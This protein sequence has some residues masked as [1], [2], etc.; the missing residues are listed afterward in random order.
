MC[1]SWD[2]KGGKKKNKKKTYDFS[3]SL[4]SSASCVVLNRCNFNGQVPK[5]A[6]SSQSKR[7]TPIAV[8]FLNE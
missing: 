2:K 5:R 6:P 4:G 1:D 3:H 7:F 8:L